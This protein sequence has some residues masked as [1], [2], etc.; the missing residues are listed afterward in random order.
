MKTGDV[1]IYRRLNGAFEFGSEHVVHETCAALDSV[2]VAG[3]DSIHQMSEFMVRETAKPGQWWITRSK[4][5]V[6]V[7]SIADGTMMVAV[8]GLGDQ[9]AL[10]LYYANGRFS[11]TQETAMDLICPALGSGYSVGLA[12]GSYRLEDVP[13]CA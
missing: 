3:S 5:I 12:V 4:V 10:E 1:V 6:L 8:P 9:V 11:Q 13:C 2:M 7:V